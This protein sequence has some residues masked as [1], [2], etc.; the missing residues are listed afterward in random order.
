VREAADR[1]GI[2]PR[3]VQ[4]LV[5]GGELVQP[6]RG[7]LDDLSVDRFLAVR[8]ASRTRA[9]SEPTAWGAVALLS[10]STPG[11]MGE[12]QRSRLRGRLRSITAPRL[13]ERVRERADV[14]RYSGHPAA[15]A[16]VRA[17]IVDT[18]AAHRRLGLADSTRVDGYVGADDDLAA[19]VS[20]HGLIRDDRG[21]FTLRATTMDRST[22]Q[23]L[24]EKDVVLAALDLAESLDDRERRAGLD[25]L[26]RALER[27]RA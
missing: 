21:T 11:W 23:D 1:L 3:Q 14:G 26:E 18:S 6:V 9:W 19:I 24:A 4:H 7:A 20:Q 22:I 8:G 17:E 12:S 15:A 10:G 13:V 2:T 27:L 16:R 5:A 25:A